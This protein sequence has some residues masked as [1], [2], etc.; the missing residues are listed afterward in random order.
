MDILKTMK[1]QL[2][3]WLQENNIIN[4]KQLSIIILSLQ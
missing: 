4:V 2:I 1:S 3:M